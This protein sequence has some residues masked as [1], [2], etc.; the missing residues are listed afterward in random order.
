MAVISRNFKTAGTLASAAHVCMF[1]P[2]LN[3][4]CT[5]STCISPTGILRAVYMYIY[6]HVYTFVLSLT[7]ITAKGLHTYLVLMLKNLVSMLRR[8]M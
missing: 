5:Y 7:S 1:I 4:R 6:I 8:P 2:N 3:V